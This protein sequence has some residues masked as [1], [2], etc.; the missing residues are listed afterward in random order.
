MSTI[1]E[2][3]AGGVAVITGAGSGIGAGL[4]RHAAATGMPASACRPWPLRSGPLALKR[5]Q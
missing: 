4:A 2:A 3:F 5:W 1:S